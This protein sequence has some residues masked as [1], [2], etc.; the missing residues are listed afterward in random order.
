MAEGAQIDGLLEKI[1]D[2]VFKKL[3][4]S[5]DLKLD[6]IDKSPRS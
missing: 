4:S 6:Q 3:S 5:L 2:T 1:S